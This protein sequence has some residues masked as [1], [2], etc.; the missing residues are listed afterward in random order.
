M[1]KSSAEEVDVSRKVA[2]TECV[3]VSKPIGADKSICFQF[4]IF[5]LPTE[6]TRIG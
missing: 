5:L 6:A 3:R 4:A 1:A 2:R